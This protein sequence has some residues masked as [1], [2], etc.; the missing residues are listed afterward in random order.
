MWWTDHS[1][2]THM[3]LHLRGDYNKYLTYS[4]FIYHQ[5][6]LGQNSRS[7]Y[8]YTPAKMQK[9]FLWIGCGLDHCMSNYQLPC[10]IT[11]FLPAN[12][13]LQIN[14]QVCTGDPLGW[15]FGLK[16]IHWWTTS[17]IKNLYFFNEWWTINNDKF[18]LVKLFERE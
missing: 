13:G 14:G 7:F 2:S 10:S 4:S 17:S 5:D 3:V 9:H 16:W 12:P 6:E 11:Q 1:A 18:H 8:N 15:K